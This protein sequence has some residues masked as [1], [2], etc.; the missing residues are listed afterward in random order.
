MI[1]VNNSV[2]KTECQQTEWRVLESIADIGHYGDCGLMG[3]LYKVEMEGSEIRV[4]GGLQDKLTSWL[5]GDKE[6]LG[7][8]SKQSV[9]QITNKVR[10]PLVFPVI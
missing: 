9:V 6:L 2:G 1:K 7:Q 3:R 4:P 5:E 10:P 8:S